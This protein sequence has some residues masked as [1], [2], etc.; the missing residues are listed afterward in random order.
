MCT[1]NTYN[2]GKQEGGRYLK[3][4]PDSLLGVICLQHNPPLVTS[5][6]RRG[7]SEIEI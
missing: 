2:G 4:L 1:N 5:L 3:Q 6:P 7:F